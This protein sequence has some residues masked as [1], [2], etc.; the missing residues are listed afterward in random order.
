MLIDNKYNLGELVYLKT[1]PEQ[2]KRM[3]VGIKICL[4]GGMYY[5]L[6]LGIEETNHYELEFTKEKDHAYL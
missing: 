4:D 5:S 3:I 6:S 1:D 2:N